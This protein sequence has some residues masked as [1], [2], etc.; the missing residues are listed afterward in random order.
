MVHVLNVQK[1]NQT[2]MVI[3]L[4]FV[5]EN[6]IWLTDITQFVMKFSMCHL[7]V[8]DISIPVL[9]NSHNVCI[10]V[11]IGSPYVEHVFNKTV[12]KGGAALM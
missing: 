8:A 6:M 4:P 10:D 9:E 7:K 12:E 5:K 11:T 1:V 3:T 2:D